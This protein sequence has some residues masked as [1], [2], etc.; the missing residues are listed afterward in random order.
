VENVS[1][2]TFEGKNSPGRFLSSIFS[3]STPPTN[4]NTHYSADFSICQGAYRDPQP[5]KLNITAAQIC[6]WPPRVGSYNN[7]ILMA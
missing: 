2:I 4:P 7:R 5:K 3:H 1:N 6:H